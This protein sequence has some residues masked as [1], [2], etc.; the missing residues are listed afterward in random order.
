MGNDNVKYWH[1]D[2]RHNLKVDLSRG[3]PE[4]DILKKYQC[5]SESLYDYKYRIGEQ[6]MRIKRDQ[7]N[8]GSYEL[9]SLANTLNC[10]RECLSQPLMLKKINDNIIELKTEI[11]SLKQ[12]IA[13]I[14]QNK[15]NCYDCNDPNCVL[16]SL[17]INN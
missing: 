11:A 5:S 15:N 8:C 1:K 7:Y 17:P 6:A 4:E 2:V 14:S 3:I 13:N 16:N 10:D 12:D 9:D